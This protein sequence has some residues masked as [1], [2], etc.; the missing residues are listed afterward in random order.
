MLYVECI[1]SYFFVPW[2]FYL[3]RRIRT[4][5]RASSWYKKEEN[6][7]RLW[8]LLIQ[9]NLDTI[10]S[11]YQSAALYISALKFLTVHPQ[12][13][14]EWGLLWQTL[15][16]TSQHLGGKELLSNRELLNE[17][18]TCACLTSTEVGGQAFS[19]QK[20]SVGLQFPIQTLSAAS[21]A[22]SLASEDITLLFLVW[23]TKTIHR[24]QQVPLKRNS[25]FIIMMNMKMWALMGQK[26]DG[27]AIP[28]T[29]HL[30]SHVHLYPYTT[31]LF[32]L[33]DIWSNEE[34]QFSLQ[35]QL[36]FI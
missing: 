8:I 11:S 5:I 19:L 29:S 33:S 31:C 23:D 21:E 36:V 15:M 3:G 10:Y 4:S 34:L 14:L 32:V 30:H 26:E 1:L 12:G 6:P 27:N 35:K 7:R 22:H 17:H 9:P 2:Y 18:R 20:L 28:Y 25:Y 24:V 13:L 16:D